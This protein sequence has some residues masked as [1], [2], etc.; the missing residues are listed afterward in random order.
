MSLVKLRLSVIGTLAFIIGAST[1]FFTIILSLTNAFSLY[2]M[3]FFVVGFNILQWLV[4]PYLIDAIYHVKEVQEKDHPKLYDMVKR[5]CQRANFPM[6]RVMIANMPIPNAFA[7]GSPVAGRRVAVTTELLKTLEDEEVEAVLG[8]E[9]GHLKHRDV[10]IMM[11]ASVLPAIFYYIGFSFMMS[12]M[13]GRKDR[14]AGGAVLVGIAAMALYW[15]LSLFVMGLSR[16]REYYADQHAV[17]TVD[18]GARKLSEGLAKITMASGRYKMRHRNTGGISSFKALLISDPDRADQ[19]EVLLAQSG[20]VRSDS[21]LVREIL[22][23]KV[24]GSDRFM[25]LFSTHPNVVKRLRALA[26][27]A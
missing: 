10:Q 3:V 20:L 26:K 11:F 8:H 4:A 2:T 25:E 24:T 22:S 7:Y 12:G 16:L 14:N 5:I 1:L 23:R 19:D 13:W 21:E 17:R 6:P 15:I 27:S 9:I 18:D